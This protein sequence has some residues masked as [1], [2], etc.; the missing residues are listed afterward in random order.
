MWLN[1]RAK[2]PYNKAIDTQG[3]EEYS[4]WDDKDLLGWGYYIIYFLSQRIL[5][6]WIIYSLNDL[7]DTKK[8]AKGNDNPT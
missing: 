3:K 5:D 1:V 4:N 7:S 6:K 8:S 2:K